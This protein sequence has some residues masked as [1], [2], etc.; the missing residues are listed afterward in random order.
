MCDVEFDGIR[1]SPPSKTA[2]ET[3]SLADLDRN[4]HAALAILVA[5]SLL[6]SADGEILERRVLCRV[7]LD[8]LQEDE[9]TGACASGVECRKIGGQVSVRLVVGM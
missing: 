3:K 9:R 6:R 4:S 2:Y 8:T 1:T 7:L 5:G